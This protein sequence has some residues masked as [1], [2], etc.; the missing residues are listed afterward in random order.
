MNKTETKTI[1]IELSKSEV[2]KLILGQADSNKASLWL[3]SN[4]QVLLI[5]DM[6]VGNLSGA[7]KICNIR[8]LSDSDYS[9]EF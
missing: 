7:H 2:V 5:W 8:D 1:E 6:Q 4:D 9:D 3:C